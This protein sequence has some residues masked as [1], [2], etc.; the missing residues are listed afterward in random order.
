MADLN[1]LVQQR[2]ELKK[3]FN[4]TKSVCDNEAQG[5]LKPIA[6]E[7]NKVQDQIDKIIEANAGVNA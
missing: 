5:K 7:Y 1:Q 4:E 6:D 3:R 2:A